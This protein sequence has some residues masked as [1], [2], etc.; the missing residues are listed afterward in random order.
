MPLVERCGIAY[1]EK[2]LGQ[3]FCDGSAQQIIDLQ[4]AEMKHVEA[5]LRLATAVTNV[6]KTELGFL[7]TLGNLVS[8]ATTLEIRHGF[9]AIVP[10][11]GG[12]DNVL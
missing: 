12:G 1:N 4:L 6:E 3:L 7:L 10:C 11:R 2:T 9:S 8:K 5:E